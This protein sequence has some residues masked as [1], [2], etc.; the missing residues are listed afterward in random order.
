[1]ISIM[2]LLRAA[3]TIL[4]AFYAVIVITMYVRQDSLT[5][6]ADTL[7]VAPA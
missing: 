2:G 4:P 3:A 1:M 5:F 6:G 7:Q